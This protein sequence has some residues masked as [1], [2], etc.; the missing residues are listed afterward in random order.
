MTARDWRIGRAAEHLAAQHDMSVTATARSMRIVAIPLVLSTRERRPPDTSTYY[1]FQVTSPKAPPSDGVVNWLTGK[2]AAV[3]AGLGKAPEGSWKVNG[4]CLR[5]FCA[6]VACVQLRTFRYGEWLV[7]RIDFQE[8][9][10]K[11]VDPSLGP[12][13]INN[14]KSTVVSV[15]LHSVNPFMFFC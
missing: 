15:S 14:E 9:A 7:D 5:W 12:S 11:S 8:F 3:W 1:H 6:Q 10:L 2:A 4:H 13:V